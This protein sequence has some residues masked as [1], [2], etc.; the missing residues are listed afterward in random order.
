MWTST[1]EPWK[2]VRE[3]NTVLALLPSCQNDA[4]LFLGGTDSKGRSTVTPPGMD[5]SIDSSFTVPDRPAHMISAFVSLPAV[6]GR[7]GHT[8]T[9]RTLKVEAIE[10]TVVLTTVP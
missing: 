6:N 7:P 8:Q 3:N 10:A 1:T 2:A 5:R 9:L 4:K